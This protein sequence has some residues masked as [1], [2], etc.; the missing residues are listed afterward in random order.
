MKSAA[1]WDTAVTCAFAAEQSLAAV[2]LL[3]SEKITP[4]DAPRSLTTNTY[5]VYW[6][7]L[8]S[9]QLELSRSSEGPNQSI[10][11]LW[12][13]ESASAIRAG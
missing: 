9:C 7:I 12:K 13:E 11:M 10:S 3:T 1:N 8:A 6:K 5:P 4:L 2:Q